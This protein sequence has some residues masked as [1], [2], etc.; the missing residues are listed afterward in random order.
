MSHMDWTKDWD[1]VGKV[2]DRGAYV[3]FDGFGI[4]WPH[5]FNSTGLV[6]P[7]DYERALGIVELI[8]R[9][10]LQKI[11]LSHDVCHKIHLKKYGG[12]GFS[13]LLQ[14]VIPILKTVGVAESQIRT[15]MMDN[16]RRFFT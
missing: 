16:P 7:T 11:M 12:H 2:I 4:E 6:A 15:M 9:G 5:G 13:H 10:Y 8:K 14:N 3:A 1:Y